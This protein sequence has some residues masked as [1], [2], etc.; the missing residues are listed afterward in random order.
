MEMESFSQTT[1]SA[2]GNCRAAADLLRDG[3]LL[4]AMQ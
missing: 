2:A 1:T 3:E 4:A